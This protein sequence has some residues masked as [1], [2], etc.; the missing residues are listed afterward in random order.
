MRIGLFGQFGSGNAG[1]DGSLEAMLQLLKRNCP[2]ADLLCICARPDIISEKYNVA[3]V[4]VGNPALESDLFRLLDKAL[5]QLPRRLAGFLTAIS[6]AHGL[7]IIIV[8]GTGIL[9]DFNEGPFGW[10]F[11]IL[12][13]C[14]AAR[15]GRAKL[16]F[17]SVG[18]GPADHPVS[19]FFFRKAALSAVFRSYRD[20]ISHDFMKSLGVHAHSDTVSADIAFA[21]PP[22]SNATHDNVGGRVGLG[23]MTYRGWKRRAANA[24][25]IYDTYL[26][27][28]AELAKAL[29]ASGRE[30]R[31]L[32]G[33]KG[34]VQAIGDLM[35]R[36]DSPDAAKIIIEPVASLHELM[37]QIAQTDIVVASRYHNIVCALAM[38][39]PAISLG[40]AAKNEALLHDTGLDGFGHHIERF[41]PQTILAQIDDMFARRQ[42]LAESVE[43]GVAQYRLKLAQQEETLRVQL[44]TKRKS[45]RLLS[46]G[47]RQRA[48]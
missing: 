8:P 22:A 6:V 41:D 9:D 30:V 33:D 37:Q 17:V 15:L 5:L 26:G 14:L 48:S 25:D 11:V 39:R 19:R 16:A 40:Y 24:S 23:V 43:A 7:D 13:W 35:A 31:L 46:P 4:P 34:D 44:L 1:N 32:T 12:R 27:K 18:A 45:V 42:Q 36:I 10:P 2:D 3:T 21:L 20:E 38:G 47:R 29:L 28:I